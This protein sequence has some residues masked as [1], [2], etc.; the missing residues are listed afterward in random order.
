MTAE[1]IMRLKD[2]NDRKKMFHKSIAI[3]RMAR[4]VDEMLDYIRHDW[5]C[6][7]NG[8]PVLPAMELATP[9]DHLKYAQ[10]IATQN[11]IEELGSF[12]EKLKL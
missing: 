2:W 3:D 9:E 7:G 10:M 6:T 4:L 5:N 12:G 1:Q 8:P 11:A